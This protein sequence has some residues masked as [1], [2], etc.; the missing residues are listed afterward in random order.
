MTLRSMARLRGDRPLGPCS[1]GCLSQ[2]GAD[3]VPTEPRP[4][5]LRQVVAWCTVEVAPVPPATPPSGHRPRSLTMAGMRWTATAAADPAPPLQLRVTYPLP[6]EDELAP[7][8]TL[9]GW[10]PALCAASPPP[11][12]RS[13]RR[14]RWR[15]RRRSG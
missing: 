8:K 4:A 2:H 13:A 14:A 1:G 11:S 9:G 6:S 5:R 15:A 10:V 3:P 7:L 12:P